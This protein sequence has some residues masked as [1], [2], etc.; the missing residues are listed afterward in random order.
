MFPTATVT[1]SGNSLHVVHGDDSGLYVRFYF[2]KVHE[3]H[4]VRINIPGDSR[5]EWDRAATEQDKM[6]FSKQWE[7]YKNQQ[8]Q[9]GTET[10][11]KDW[12]AITEGQVRELNARNVQTVEQLA[13]MI[14]SM[15]L[16]C[17]MGTR[18]LVRKAQGF[19]SDMASKRQMEL[20]NQELSKRD[21]KIALLEEKLNQLIAAQEAKATPEKATIHVPKKASG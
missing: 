2:N 15:I 6:R 5:T 17:P 13:Q 19:I 18:D 10:M 14:D 9:F 20:A 16:A 12:D 21:T 11:L 1:G 7:L 3:K 4:Y 8:N